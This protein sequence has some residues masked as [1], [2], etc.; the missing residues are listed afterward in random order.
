LSCYGL[1]SHDLNIT[2]GSKGECTV[3]N[4]LQLMSWRTSKSTWQMWTAK[5]HI[6]KTKWSGP[7]AQ[8]GR[9]CCISPSPWLA[10]L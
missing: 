4:L 2:G 10:A 1:P 3:Y 7:A 5:I 6:C 9:V 8:C